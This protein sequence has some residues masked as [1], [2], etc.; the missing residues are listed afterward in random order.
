MCFYRELSTDENSVTCAALAINGNL[1]PDE[2]SCGK[3]RDLVLKQRQRYK[4]RN[5]RLLKQVHQMARYRYKGQLHKVKEIKE[6]IQRDYGSLRSCARR[7]SLT[8]G[9]M[10]SM[11]LR[12]KRKPKK[13]YSRKFT[14]DVKNSLSKFFS[15]DEV[16]FSVPEARYAK[17]K[18]LRS[19]LKETCKMYNQSR[20]GNERK[21][22]ISTFRKYRPKCVKLQREIPV[23][24]CLCQTCV[25][26]KL[27]SKALIGASVQ[28]ISASTRSAVDFT[29]C[30]YE[31][32]HSSD[33]AEEQLIADYG[34]RRC[35]YRE[36]ELCGVDLMRAKIE[37][38]NADI[39]AKNEDVNY[40]I[41][42]N[43]TKTFKGREVS[44][45]EKI[46]KSCSLKELVNLYLAALHG[47]SNHLF[48][49][50]WQ[51]Q[52]LTNLIQNVPEH[53]VVM[54]HDFSENISC[55]SA[56]E[57]ASAYFDRTLVSLHP[58]VCFYRC[59][60]VN[61]SKIVRHEILHVSS[62]TK[63]DFG[64]YKKIHGDSLKIVEADIGS[65]I[66]Q[67]TNISDNDP[68]CYKN[69]RNLLFISKSEV[70][71]SHLFTAKSHGKF[72]S[73]NCGGRFKQ[74]IKRSILSERAELKN[75][76]DIFEFASSNYATAR[77]N[78]NQC[79]H[80]QI[81]VNLV[82]NISRSWKDDSKTAEGT[83]AMHAVQS[84]GC[85][86]LVKM[87]TIACLCSNCLNDEG[88]CL[89][90][91]YC[92]DW[93]LKQVSLKTPK[94]TAEQ[95]SSL[96]DKSEKVLHIV[97]KKAIIDIYSENEDIKTEVNFS[98][99]EGTASQCAE[100]ECGVDSATVQSESTCKLV[101]DLRCEEQVSAQCENMVDWERILV[102]MERCR[103]YPALKRLF[104][105]LSLPPLPS[106][107]TGRFS[108]DSDIIDT[109]ATSLIPVSRNVPQD[110]VATSTRMDGNCF[111]R[112]LAKYAL[113]RQECHGE[114]R[115]RLV[116]E[117]IL[118]EEYYLNN[119]Y[120]KVGG[121]ECVTDDN[122]VLRYMQYSNHYN[123][124]SPLNRQ[125]IV[126][127]YRAEWFEFR[128]LRTWAGVLQ[129]HAAASI[130]KR[131]V[132]S[133]YSN[134][135]LRTIYNDLDRCMVPIGDS[136]P[137]AEVCH[138]TWTKSNVNGRLDHFVPLLPREK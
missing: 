35:I 109:V 82:R 7:L 1:Q 120:L 119:D 22:A 66:R 41:W 37:E 118:R 71:M 76:Q 47:I 85:P 38:A 86:G 14:T 69:K 75:A 96:N 94:L 34:Y 27:L 128:L 77:T 63:H 46:A 113:N 74:F 56:R 59:K 65:E 127:I 72:H 52:Q 13:Q 21:V 114:F 51:Y 9:Q 92:T 43:R 20:R 104:L 105:S 110:L 5:E 107:Y 48:E 39:L 126:K 57:P 130:L 137:S 12:R 112:S 79:N 30:P 60:S 10:Q 54:N 95:W 122:Y 125:E 3:K 6:E 133:H 101:D 81:S 17:K 28:G 87:R 99:G 62:D 121:N 111:T 123:P 78:D 64:H 26:M 68:K 61:C 16:S 50:K 134:N 53:H 55:Y 124:C 138:I 18:F 4:G 116:Q 11:Y 49:A 2:T 100:M 83:R 115:V 45:I 42:E 89:N 67:I 117:G 131:T 44:R 73:D 23:N 135:V 88:S 31:H 132:W 58:T 129:F 90:P 93:A 102:Q 8:W 24:T 84:L 80:F 32:L 108:I 98:G 25:N 91:E 40:H 103:T 97:D 29:L 106:V 36:C 33:N 70:Q 136:C 15:S 19:N